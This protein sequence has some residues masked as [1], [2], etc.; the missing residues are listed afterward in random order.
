MY[1]ARRRAL[2]TIRRRRAGSPGIVRH[3]DA[4][5]PAG[6]RRRKARSMASCGP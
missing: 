2:D 5:S 1:T 3:P 6:S 4:G